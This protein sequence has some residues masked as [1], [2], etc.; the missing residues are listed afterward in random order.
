MLKITILIDNTTTNGP[1]SQDFFDILAV[2]SS[3]VQD[4][5]FAL[6]G[7]SSTFP[8]RFCLSRRLS[9]SLF[10]AIELSN[11]SLSLSF[12]PAQVGMIGAL[13]ISFSYFYNNSGNFESVLVADTNDTG[14]F[15]F[16]VQSSG[17]SPT[18]YGFRLTFPV[19]LPP[20]QRPASLF[21]YSTIRFSALCQFRLF[22]LE[23]TEHSAVY[24]LVAPSFVR[25]LLV[26]PVS[27]PWW[28]LRR[29]L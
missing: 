8:I 21:S 3:L 20:F 28:I 29:P 22:N 24:S 25:L 13:R 12:I 7:G 23:A 9:H 17:I 6:N 2:T 11:T 1:E 10:S 5:Y 19:C 26:T 18:S 4:P 16:D 27:Q 15:V 14:L